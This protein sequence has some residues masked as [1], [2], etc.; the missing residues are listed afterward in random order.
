MQKG[1]TFLLDLTWT[2]TNRIMAAAD[3]FNIPYIHADVSS[4]TFLKVLETYLRARGANDVVYI[5]D[6]PENADMAIYFLITE[7]QLRTIIFDRLSDNAIER[8]KSVRPYPS[9]FAIIA[10]TSQMSA[11]FKRALQG[12]LVSKPDK[13]NLIFMDV[14]NES[15]EHHETFPAMSR[16]L[17]EKST[18]CKLMNMEEGCTCPVEFKPWDAH[19]ENVVQKVLQQAL[20]DQLPLVTQNDCSVV[21]SSAT[22]DISGLLRDLRADERFWMPDGS[23]MLRYNLNVSIWSSTE[24][25]ES[26]AIRIG[27]IVKGVVVPSEGNRI[28]ATKRYFRVG[29]TEVRIGKLV[30]DFI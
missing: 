26:D 5:F 7:S 6:S 19:L 25:D 20:H 10:N 22:A 14:E 8:I 4:Q 17:M 24:E 30:S 1:A 28:K 27:S 9:F 23:R 15:F 2:D 21:G 12:G 16:L 18:C 3:N 29:T 13:W 11:L